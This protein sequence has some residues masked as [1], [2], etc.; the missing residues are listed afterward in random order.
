MVDN[1]GT[2]YESAAACDLRHACVDLSH[3][4]NAI[5]RASGMRED[6]RAVVELARI[7]INQDRY[8]EAYDLTER[9]GISNPMTQ[10]AWIRIRWALD[11][12]AEENRP[13][14][15]H[16]APPGILARIRELVGGR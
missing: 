2:Y 7:C 12:L 3:R 9:R 1:W 10:A 16:P 4:L 15:P 13:Y 6:I 8:S 5:V 14:P 11:L